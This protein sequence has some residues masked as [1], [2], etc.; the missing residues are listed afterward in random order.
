MWRSIA[1]GAQ[2]AGALHLQDIVAASKGCTGTNQD[3]YCLCVGNDA[4]NLL[5]CTD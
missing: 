1:C 3:C 4:S 5:H 2:Q